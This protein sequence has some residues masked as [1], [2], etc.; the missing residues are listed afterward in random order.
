MDDK[1]KQKAATRIAGLMQ[2]NQR[3][4]DAIEQAGVRANLLPSRIR[5]LT[6]FLVEQGIMTEEQQ[7]DEAEKWEL[8]LRSELQPA[9]EQVKRAMSAAGVPQQ[10][11]SGLIVPGVNAPRNMRG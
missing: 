2:T 10:T 6:T 4:V 5:H 3:M 7:I 1:A 11:E 9:Y 8:F